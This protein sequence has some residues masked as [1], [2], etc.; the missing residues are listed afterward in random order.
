MQ[1]LYQE[2]DWDDGDGGYALENDDTHAFSK[3]DYIGGNSYE[4]DD[5]RDG[6]SNARK[7]DIQKPVLRAQQKQKQQQSNH[8][9]QHQKVQSK[10]VRPSQLGNIPPPLPYEASPPKK[11]SDKDKLVY[12][13]EPREVAYKPHTKP[14]PR[15]EYIEI[16]NLK[17]D[18]NTE[19]LVTKRA[20]AERIKEFAKNLHDFNRKNIEQNRKLPASTE[21]R[22]ILTDKAKHESKRSKALEFARNIP[23]PKVE[24]TSAGA[25]V[26]GAAGKGR[27]T[28]RRQEIDDHYVTDNDEYGVEYGDVC[29]RQGLEL[30]HEESRRQVEAIKRSMGLM[31]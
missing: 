17:P 20:N 30:K 21:V 4:D 7:T 27:G 3:Y 31:K 29:R 8:I 26:S 13:R 1:R 22:D 25:S 12:S 6:Y 14:I 23:K 11:L 18:L 2:D 16:Q 10:A 28:S 9:E 24:T 5:G 19:E 15:R